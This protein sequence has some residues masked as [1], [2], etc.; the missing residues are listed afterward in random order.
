MHMSDALITPVVGG[1]TLAAGSGLLGYSVRSIKTDTFEQ[2]LPLM[3]VMG[4]FLFA[5]QMIN[6]AIPGTGSSGHLGGGM[7]LAIIL[8]PAAGFITMASVL[9]IQAL[10]FADGGLLAFGCNLINL[11]FFTAYVAYPL[12]FKPMTSTI[13]SNRRLMSA[14]IM[15]SVVG[16]QLGALGVVAQT[17]LSGRT[18]LPLGT[19]LMFMQPIH[20]AIGVV[21]GIITGIIV[22]YLHSQNR[23]LIYGEEDHQDQ[24]RHPVGRVLIRIM[25]AAMLVGGF[26]SLYASSNPD[27]LEW[28]VI[29]TS[30]AKEAANESAIVHLFSSLQEQL[31][32]MP[33]YRLEGQSDDVGTSISGIAGS[34]LT[35]ITAVGAGWLIK[36]LRQSG[37]VSE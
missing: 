26:L 23:Q 21:E 18:E 28:A 34:L 5:A 13:R 22:I 6:F 37:A 27:G 33:D 12:I 15:A 19:F 1:S 17:W 31:A 3:G 2:R 11:G 7:L 29:N 10:F 8:G 36:R 24:N 4:A 25:I 9:L 32:P 30:G 35:L 14:A 20:L 16:L